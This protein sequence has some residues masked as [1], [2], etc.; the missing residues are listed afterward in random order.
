MA[1]RTLY[2]TNTA[3]LAASGVSAALDLGGG[4][5]GSPAFVG[6]AT[7]RLSQIKRAWLVAY[8]KGAVAGVGAKAVYTFEQLD[9]QGNYITIAQLA[10]ITATGY[11]TALLGVTIP[12]TSSGKVRWTVT[13]TNPTL[14][15]VD[16]SLIGVDY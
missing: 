10:D 16:V 3:S 11:A 6:G 4:S 9:G 13:G 1:Q 14:A 5:D 12:L 2:N 15:D 7:G 8:V